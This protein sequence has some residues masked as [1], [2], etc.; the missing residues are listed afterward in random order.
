MERRRVA[1]STVTA[2]EL[3]SF[4]AQFLFTGDD[5]YKHARDLSGGRKAGLRS[6]N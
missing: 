3:R 5:V 6:P 2:G 1:P 4:L